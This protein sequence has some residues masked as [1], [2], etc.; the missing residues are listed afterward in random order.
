M[1]LIL[2][3]ALPVR[4]L[5]DLV[6]FEEQHLRHAFVGVD[7]RRQRRGVGKLQSDVPFPL[8]FQRRYIDYYPAIL[9]EDAPLQSKISCLGNC[10]TIDVV[11]ARNPAHRHNFVITISGRTPELRYDF[12]KAPEY[13]AVAIQDCRRPADG[14][15]VIQ[16]AT[17]SL[18][19]NSRAQSNASRDLRL[20]TAPRSIVR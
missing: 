18:L 9:D 15:G 8:R 12:G 16:R 5:A 19:G 4:G 14:A 13:R 20:A 17:D 10:Q 3:S 11:V 6:G 2:A 7:F 1:T